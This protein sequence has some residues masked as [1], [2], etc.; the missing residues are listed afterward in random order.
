MITEREKCCGGVFVDDIVLLAP[1]KSSLKSLLNK[2]HEWDIKNK[3]TFEISKCATLVI[4]VIKF[5][6]SKYY[7]NLHLLNTNQYIYIDI[8]FNES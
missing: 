4:K 6:A 1:S 2:A 3:M 8:P 7:E 5:I